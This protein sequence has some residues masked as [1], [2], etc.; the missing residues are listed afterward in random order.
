MLMP[1]KDVTRSR[2]LLSSILTLYHPLVVP[3][4]TSLSC[5]CS[6]S[7]SSSSSSG[8]E[9][10]SSFRPFY[11][12][13]EDRPVDIA[14]SFKN[15]FKSGNNEVLARIYEILDGWGGNGD[16]EDLT[17]HATDLAL[18][19]LGLRLSESF[20]LDA[21]AYGRD[22]LS[23]LK[24][25]DWAGRQPG[26]FHTRATYTA[27]FKILSKAELMSVMFDFLKMHEKARFNQRVRFYDT[28]IIGYAVARK[29]ERALN[30]FGRMRFLG[31]D[32]D[33][34]GYHVL[35]NSLAENNSLGGFE[36]ILE[37]IRLRGHENHVT[38]S[39][40]MKYY[41]IRK[42]LCEAEEYL[43]SL[44][45]SGKVLHGP[46]VSVLLR[47]LCENNM[48]ERAGEL[49]VEFGNSGLVPH[50]IAL[51]EWIRYLVRAGR[52]DEALAYFRDKQSSEGYIPGLFQY[53]I[54]IGRLLKKK[55]LHEV[56]DLLME[57]KDNHITPDMVTMNIVIC[58]FCKAGMVDVALELYNSR[59][60]FGLSPSLMA[61]K[62]LIHTLCLNGSAAEAYGVF[63]KLIDEG[64]FL[65]RGIFYEVANALF[66]E[67]KVDKME[68]LLI[69]ALERNFLPRAA[70]YDKLIEALCQAGRLR[71]SYLIHGELNNIAS[72]KSY[73]RLITGFSKSNRGDIAAQLLVEMRQKGFVPTD[74]LYRVV[75][76]SLLKGDN[77]KAHFLG[78]LET[79]AR[80]GAL[81]EISRLFVDEA[82]VAKKPELVKGVF[83]IK[84][85]CGIN[86]TLASYI[87]ILRSYL[88]SERIMDALNFF[89]DMR[90]RGIKNR[91][92]YNSIITG[93]CRV[94][95]TDLALKLLSE[96]MND[97][98]TPNI[99]CYENL[100]QSLCLEKRYPEAINLVN[101][102]EK[103]GRCLTSF[104]GNAFLLHSL[105]APEIYDI[106]VRLRGVREE[107]FSGSSMLSLIIGVFSGRLRVNLHSE[108]LEELIEKCFPP[109][110]Y[111]YNLLLLRAS[112]SEIDQACELFDRMCRKGYYPDRF[113]YNIMLRAFLKHGRKEEAK[114]CFEEM[115]R[116]GFHPAVDAR[117]LYRE[118]Y[119]LE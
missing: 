75:I 78:L 89:N 12:I 85:R 112:W 48:F 39:V 19:Q 91:R 71:D 53:N 44:V 82:A 51:V 99:G 1:L 83:E 90:Q 24:F 22:V 2:T 84:Q 21:L 79:L 76:R 18:K 97:K 104:M 65:D 34:F 107:E 38:H 113:T 88:R 30:L 114:L 32:L 102:Y 11:N 20:V 13:V 7:S 40:V 3:I 103:M 37:Q 70:I 98:L 49:I 60:Q 17:L 101:D 50:E 105:R 66:R 56:Y 73:I 67:S 33:D 9:S 16:G 45:H 116:N 5:T 108:N 64:Y 27:I 55:Q 8:S 29:P 23:C 58:F 62:S 87:Y 15:W 69:L 96:M 119:Q 92:L 6:Y 10:P 72:Q 100:V 36:T 46:E 63:K 77:P 42:R 59:S 80:Y 57:M 106:C 74:A 93:L 14:A 61:Y 86:L 110:K 41:C 35:L 94:K 52:S 26:F 118:E 54:L 25:F 81:K 68:E 111:T 109:D 4:T 43:N 28:L 117:K 31:L 115:L 47:A 95:R